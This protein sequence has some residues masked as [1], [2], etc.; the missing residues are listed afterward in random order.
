VAWVRPGT[1]TFR[2]S[3]PEKE[4][5]WVVLARLH[6]WVT[7]AE[8]TATMT[9]VMRATDSIERERAVR[10]WHRQAH[11]LGGVSVTHAAPQSFTQDLTPGTYYLIDLRSLM[12]PDP[13][14][15]VRQVSWWCCWLGVMRNSHA[16]TG[17]LPLWVHQ[18]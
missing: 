4:S 1:V 10:T 7:I 6:H 9:T 15:P 18:W 3:T 11:V 17:G 14:E 8:F 12:G 16:S 13:G 5:R 2:V